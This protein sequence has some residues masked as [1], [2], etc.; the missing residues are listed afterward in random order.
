MVVGGV[1]CLDFWELWEVVGW[2]GW[3]LIVVD[4]D[5]K[6]I[7]VCK[8]W[9][10]KV[11]GIVIGNV[12]EEGV[13]D[14]KGGV[15]GIIDVERVEEEVIGCGCCV[16]VLCNWGIVIGWCCDVLLKVDC[17]GVVKLVMKEIN[18]NDILF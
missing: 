12:V 8:G 11:I 17:F 1:C 15:G 3:E 5:C 6:I 14:R 2:E 13:C 7:W 9:I 16:G 4:W 18:F 10:F